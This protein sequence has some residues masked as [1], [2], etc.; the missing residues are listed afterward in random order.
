MAATGGVELTSWL[1]CSLWPVSWPNTLIRQDSANQGV[2]K[3]RM[4][5]LK[6]EAPRESCP[7]RAFISMD[8][9]LNPDD[10][11]PLPLAPTPMRCGGPR[12]SKPQWM[13]TA[14]IGPLRKIERTSPGASDRSSASL[15]TFYA[16]AAS[17]PAP[18]PAIRAGHRVPTTRHIRVALVDRPDCGFLRTVRQQGAWYTCWQWLTMH[19][20]SALLAKRMGD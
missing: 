15:S 20:V 11:C 9:Q 4:G 3:L 7:G 19:S 13:C 12:R 5:G 18:A 16:A 8:G 14:R 10:N 2:E 17:Q 1:T 6:S